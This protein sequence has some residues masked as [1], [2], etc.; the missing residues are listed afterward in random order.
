MVKLNP[1]ASLMF[2]LTAAG[3]GDEVSLEGAPCP[4]VDGY[5]CCEGSD[6]CVS[7]QASCAH[8]GI[9]SWRLG[10]QH[11]SCAAA[12]TEV[13]RLP[14]INVSATGRPHFDTWRDL[15]V[16]EAA[17]YGCNTETDAD[18]SEND[19]DICFALRGDGQGVC[20]YVDAD[21]WCDGEGEVFSWRDGDCVLCMAVGS[22]A[23]A[24]AAGIAGVDCR[25]WPYPSDGKPGT[26][27]AAHEDCEPG[28][29]CGEG[30]GSG[31]GICQC[32]GLPD[33]PRPPD[34]CYDGLF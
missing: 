28:L 19:L 23:A 22:H 26:V 3:C 7:D 32:P 2:V 8:L 33:V 14:S 25:S 9:T 34:S 21:I 31:Y 20:S 11:D 17:S 10:Q 18:C 5:V 27:C 29:I 1:L 24:C 4:C 6:I 13:P 12:V 15:L 16:G 30:A